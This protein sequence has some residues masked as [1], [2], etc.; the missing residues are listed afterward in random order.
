LRIVEVMS[1]RRGQLKFAGNHG[2]NFR[3]I[4]MFPKGNDLY[5][6]FF[7]TFLAIWALVLKE[8]IVPTARQ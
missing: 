5:D 4:A 3:I 2:Q 1:G 7:A 8:T 6:S